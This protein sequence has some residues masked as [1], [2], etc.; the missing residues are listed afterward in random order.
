MIYDFCIIG[1]GIVGL[2]TAMRL[3]EM[4]PDASILLIEK[5][6]DVA[7]HQ[8]GHNSG[9]IHAGIYYEPD[10][11]KA[12]MCREGL[13][14]TLAFCK[15]HDVRFEQCGKL[16]VAT[17]PI[18]EAR[19][20]TLYDRASVNGLK[21]KRI[22][23]H[24]LEILEPNIRGT[25]ALL[26]PD[27]GIVDYR[28][29]A[30]KM[31]EL[32]SA[33]GGEIVFDQK[34]DRINE[35]SDF[36]DLGAGDSWWQARKIVVCAGLQADRLAKLAGLNIDFRIVPFR[37]EYFQL[38]PQKNGIIKHLIYPVS[39]PALPFLGVHLT[40]MIDGSVTV[41]PNAVI[42]F[43]RE[44]Y[45]KFSIN[46]NDIASSTVFSGFWKLLW[47]HRLHALN[48]LKA[49]L[50]RP[51][52]LAECQKYCPQLTTSDLLPYPAGI[53]AQLVKKNGVAVHDFLFGETER[54]L[55]VF[56]APSPAATSAIPIGRMIAEKC[57]G[58]SV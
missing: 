26:S 46:I 45:P 58:G 17:S 32:I 18:E 57:I 9:V 1:G 55:H 44:G 7:K 14:A 2:A 35:R 6:N 22:D 10:S 50:W 49:S 25:A 20:N 52:Y 47:K 27:T 41:G 3:L 48:E 54:M 8:T 38:P 42:G 30:S 11:L 40:K 19:L 53:R 36:V 16:I 28:Q 13:T 12:K 56:N 39:D 21:L 37:G 24:G 4:H 15:T 43:A 31:A 23:R 5:E 51:A 29:M 33:K 34:V